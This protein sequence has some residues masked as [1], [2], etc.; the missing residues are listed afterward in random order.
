MYNTW[1]TM[2]S[3]R[4][5]FMTPKVLNYKLEML[6]TVEHQLIEKMVIFDTKGKVLLLI[7]A[8]ASI[9][10]GNYRQDIEYTN[11]NCKIGIS[12][13]RYVITPIWSF[14]L[15]LIC[16]QFSP[17]L[18]IIYHTPNEVMRVSAISTQKR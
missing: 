15:T 10:T 17:D 3:V 8:V 2:E 18:V 7:E 5:T 16:H 13:W 1:V 14:N 4:F 11:S 12:L 9:Y 6:K